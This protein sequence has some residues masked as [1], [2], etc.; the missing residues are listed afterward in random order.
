MFIFVCSRWIS[1]VLIYF[2]IIFLLVW[3]SKMKLLF[4][5]STLIWVRG[6][7][8]SSLKATHRLASTVNWIFAMFSL[9]RET[10]CLC[11]LP[12]KSY[13]EVDFIFHISVPT[14]FTEIFWMISSCTFHP[15]TCLNGLIFPPPHPP[16]VGAGK[17][18][19][20]FLSSRELAWASRVDSSI[21]P[22]WL[23]Q[24]KSPRIKPPMSGKYGASWC[25]VRNF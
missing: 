13:S 4:Q 22:L 18:F 17:H 9:K 6:C 21:L 20:L 14:L 3:I 23:Q 15:F 25:F 5:K 10:M 7:L 11:S 8:I 24:A 12:I 16:W 19:Y 2:L 1:F